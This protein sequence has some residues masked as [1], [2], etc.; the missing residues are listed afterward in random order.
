MMNN[1]KKVTAKLTNCRMVKWFPSLFSLKFEEFVWLSKTNTENEIYWFRLV[2]FVCSIYVICVYRMACIEVAF[3]MVGVYISYH[4]QPIANT[5]HV[6]SYLTQVSHQ[7]VALAFTQNSH[8]V[9]CTHAWKIITITHSVS[10]SQAPNHLPIRK[11]F[12]FEKRL[13]E[14]K[15]NS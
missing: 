8:S 11:N 2:H 10:N 14:T 9:V 4:V 5:D 7:Q 1:R 13:S 3:V 15:T 12:V 6:I